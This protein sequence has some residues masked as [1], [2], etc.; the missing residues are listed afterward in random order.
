MRVCCDNPDDIQALLRRH[1]INP[2]RQRMEIARVLFSRAGHWSADSILGI[3]NEAHAATS[4]AT[5]YNT[6]N[7]FVER[8]LVREVIAHPNKVFYDANTSPHYHF[9]HVDTGELT[10]IATADLPIVKLPELPAGTVPEGVDI[11]VR[12]RSRPST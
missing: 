11:V 7:L 5:V 2:T 6:L 3:V 8:G 10:D 12:V 4:K 9:Y 1:R